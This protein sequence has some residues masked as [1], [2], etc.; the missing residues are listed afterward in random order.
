MPAKN[1]KKT[2]KSVQKHK[3]VNA[4][5]ST[6]QPKEL[7]VQLPAY[8]PI[9]FSAPP[10]HLEVLHKKMRALKKKLRRIEEAEKQEVGKRNKEQERLIAEKGTLTRALRD[11]EE[12]EKSLQKLD[13][14]VPLRLVRFFFKYFFYIFFL[15]IF[16][17]NQWVGI[18]FAAAATGD[19]ALNDLCTILLPPQNPPP[20]HSPLRELEHACQVAEHFLEG[21]SA[22]LFNDGTPVTCK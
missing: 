21:A 7:P 17:C 19:S 16:F 10:A 4:P 12:I 11:F 6:E 9:D 18:F 2:N 22:E 3:D 8:Q 1:N 20:S 5:P 15:F 13:L 14:T